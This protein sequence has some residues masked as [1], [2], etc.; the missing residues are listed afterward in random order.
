MGNTEEPVQRSVRVWVTLIAVM[1]GSL[2][3]WAAE[4]EIACRQILQQAIT[5]TVM[6]AD[7]SNPTVIFKG[8]KFK[9]GSTMPKWSPDGEWVAFRR[10]TNPEV[11]QV[12]GIYKIRPGGEEMTQILCAAG[13]APGDVSFSSPYDPQWS[14]DG[15]WILVSIWHEADTGA[16]TWLGLVPADVR[17]ANCYSNLVQL[18]APEVDPAT[19]DG[20]SLLGYSPTW[21]DDGS[22]I[23]T[24]E[25]LWIEDSSSDF[26]L[27]VLDIDVSGDVPTVADKHPIDLPEDLKKVMIGTGLDWQRDGGNILLFD[28]HDG[29][30]KV[31]WLDLNLETY[32]VR[33]WGHLPDGWNARWSPHNNRMVYNSGMELRVANIQY[34]GDGRPVYTGSSMIFAD[35]NSRSCLW[36]DWKR[37][38]L[39]QTCSGDSEC[40]DGKECTLD[41]CSPEGQCLNSP[42]LDGTSC[43]STGMCCGGFCS[44]PI[45]NSDSDC[46]DSDPCT[47]DS[48]F[49]GNTCAAYCSNESNGTCPSCLSKGEPC[50]PLIPCCSGSCHPIKGTCK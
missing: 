5:V 15:Q 24:F 25:E 45:C 33:N 13:T 38:P 28:T 16:D 50:D 11:D 7:G 37:G 17:P 1:L 44:S 23:A 20:W 22:K 32:E 35:Q 19:G 29:V 49:D 8:D 9:M 4:P 30:D 3:L 36:P 21:T 31:T 34:A 48:C 40:D 47:D 39:S 46:D 2:S 42:V 10:V 12:S 41:T 6:G 18:Y 26:R 14:P 43:D 27:R